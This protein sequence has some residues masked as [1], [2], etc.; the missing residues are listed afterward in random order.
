MASELSTV[1]SILSKEEI[2]YQI[3]IFM[4]CYKIIDNLLYSGHLHCLC[5][6]YRGC[7]TKIHFITNR[8]KY[9]CICQ[10]SSLFDTITL[11]QTKPDTHEIRSYFVK[12]KYLVIMSFGMKIL[13]I[14]LKVKENVNFLIF[15]IFFN[16][17]IFYL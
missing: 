9:C 6:F 15:L 7:Q 16:F 12:R 8:K 5:D 2:Q 11:Y 17:L 3:D 1:T 10:F 13:C 14:L 4:H